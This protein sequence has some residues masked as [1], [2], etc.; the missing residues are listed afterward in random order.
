MSNNVPVKPGK[1]LRVVNQN[2]Y[3]KSCCFIQWQNKLQYDS[4]LY[5]PYSII[6][7]F[8]SPWSPS[9]LYQPT[10]RHETVIV[11]VLCPLVCLAVAASSEA[12][13]RLLR[14]A[15]SNGG[16]LA[17]DDMARTSIATAMGADYLGAMGANAPGEKVQWTYVY[18]VNVLRQLKT[19]LFDLWH[20]VKFACSMGFWDMADRMMW[21]HLCHGGWH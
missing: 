8:G 7:F 9:I 16:S 2:I 3:D 21:R 17:P 12:S 4:L 18:I 20:P 14:L 6:F 11:V 1:L 19:S 15:G 5:M 13:T 10:F